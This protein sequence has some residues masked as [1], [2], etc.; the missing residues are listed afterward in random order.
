MNAP[1]AGSTPRHVRGPSALPT[2]TG[3]VS[4]V[5]DEVGRVIVA[6]MSVAGVKVLLGP[7]RDRL[8]TVIQPTHPHA[9]R[10]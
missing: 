10:M 3:L 2:T 6:D 1:T 9:A 7:D 5:H 8:N 4:D